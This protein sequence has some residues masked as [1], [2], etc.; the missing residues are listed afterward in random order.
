MFARLALV[1]AVLGLA[2]ARRRKE[3]PIG[4]EGGELEELDHRPKASGEM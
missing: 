2:A 1:L 3:L 4:H